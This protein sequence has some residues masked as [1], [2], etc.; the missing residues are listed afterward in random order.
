MPIYCPVVN[1]GI[2]CLTKSIFSEL[3]YLHVKCPYFPTKFN[4]NMNK[5]DNIFK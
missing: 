3:N 2:K 4:C 1:S 5:Y